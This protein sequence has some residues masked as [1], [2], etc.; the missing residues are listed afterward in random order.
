MVASNSVIVARSGECRC[1]VHE[2]FT[3][4]HA[5][6]M[7]G[8][9]R[10]VV[11]HTCVDWILYLHATKEASMCHNLTVKGFDIKVQTVTH[12]LVTPA[13]NRKGTVTEV[14]AP[15]FPLP[16]DPDPCPK[17]LANGRRRQPLKLNETRNTRRSREARKNRKRSWGRGRKG[18]RRG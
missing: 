9:K 17:T 4:S 16:T 3:P 5:H 1:L 18:N 2:R 14:P 11:Y 8:C 12:G 6:C 15:S 13:N 10:W 7:C